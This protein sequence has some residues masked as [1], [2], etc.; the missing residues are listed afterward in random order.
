MTSVLKGGTMATLAGEVYWL[1]CK[2]HYSRS[3]EFARLCY[4]SNRIADFYV[5]E[6]GEILK[7]DA[8]SPR[9]AF[10]R[11]VA[12]QPPISY[13]RELIL[14]C[15]Q[16]PPEFTVNV[17]G[18]ENARVVRVATAELSDAT[19]LPARLGLAAGVAFDRKTIL[20]DR[21]L[22]SNRQNEQFHIRHGNGRADNRLL[23]FHKDSSRRS[24]SRHEQRH[25]H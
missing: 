17:W 1:L 7:P 23:A 8:L 24:R 25:P 21:R 10:V 20:A 15:R 16:A 22:R 5:W 12:G 3:R 11:A 13:Q 6:P 18:V 2:G 4:A 9:S 19:L 14:D